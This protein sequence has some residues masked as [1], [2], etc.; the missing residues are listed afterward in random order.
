MF[1]NLISLTSCLHSSNFCFQSSASTSLVIIW[2]EKLTVSRAV[3]T[4]KTGWPHPS[5]MKTLKTYFVS[6]TEVCTS[7]L[8]RVRTACFSASLMQMESRTW[9]PDFCISLPTDLFF[10]LDVSSYWWQKKISHQLHHLF[11]TSICIMGLN[12]PKVFKKLWGIHEKKTVSIAVSIIPQYC[13]KF[14][15]KYFIFSSFSSYFNHSSPLTLN[16]WSSNILFLLSHI[17]NNPRLSLSCLNLSFPGLWH[18]HRNLLNDNLNPS[19]TWV[20]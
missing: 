4:N 10:S 11:C 8:M 7:S 2:K 15:C 5:Q 6:V 12:S 18:S 3:F 20:L 17:Q 19:V 16:K 1:S 13:H 9:L 14:Y